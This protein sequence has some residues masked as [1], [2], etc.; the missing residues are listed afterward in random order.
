MTT[1]LAH[2]KKLKGK[3]IPM[4]ISDTVDSEKELYET[5]LKQLKTMPHISVIH[6]KKTMRAK[7]PFRM[8]FKFDT[9]SLSAKFR[10]LEREK[11]EKSYYDKHRDSKALDVV[12]FSRSPEMFY[13]IQSIDREL[14]KNSI[15]RVT[16]CANIV[17]KC[18]LT[19]KKQNNRLKS[20]SDNNT[21]DVNYYISNSYRHLYYLTDGDKKTVQSLVRPM[22][23]IANNGVYYNEDVLIRGG[24]LYTSNIKT[25]IDILNNIDHKLLME[26]PLASKYPIIEVSLPESYDALEIIRAGHEYIPEHDISKYVVQ[27]I[28]YK[29]EHNAE[30]AE[31][32]DY[33]E[34]ELYPQGRVKSISITTL[35]RKLKHSY[36][37]DSCNIFLTNDMDVMM[38]KLRF[39]NIILDQ[40]VRINSLEEIQS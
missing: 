13:F 34:K 16:P 29:H 8:T 25:M 38:L 26:C 37:N 35:R 15:Y 12:P 22:L 2:L 33:L 19:N 18:L 1:A 3:G 36:Y 11:A 20:E 4:I 28:R 24:Y 10:E 14:S 23:Y 32:I 31:L 17:G 5:L 9:W 27:T 21:I 40:K 30:F 6:N 7:M 39:S